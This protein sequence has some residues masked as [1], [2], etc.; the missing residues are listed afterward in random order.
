M[1]TSPLV[2][3][4]IPSF[5]HA[6]YV[7]D[8]IRSVLEQTY[9][10]WQIVVVDDCS[11][12]DSVAIIERFD[13]PRITLI[14]NDRNRGINPTLARAFAASTGEFI[15]VLA[16]DDMLLPDKLERQVALLRRSGADIVYGGGIQLSEDGDR[17]AVDL[18][19]FAR[20]FARGHALRRAYTDDTSLP[21]LQSA[22]F[23]RDAFAA[24]SVYR[25]SVK[26]DDWITLIKAL[27]G[28]RVE[29]RDEPVFL[30]R[31]HATNT[32]RRYEHTFSMRLEII[33][34]A[35]PPAYRVEAL[36]RLFASQ[37]NYLAWD[38]RFAD[39]LRFLTA[40]QCLRPAIGGIIHFA[41]AVVFNLRQRRR[42]G[43]SL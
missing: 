35:T 20:D 15:D 32:F 24:L 42:T 14:R 13:D 27:E 3:V 29:F 16:S 37:A 5:N 30:Y 34:K 18:S 25:E 9:Q 31:Q 33:A 6:S 21:L 41:R 19:A 40:S 7:A 17:T 28:F 8:A 1:N 39:A 26:L 10:S 22:L 12:D 43:R 2:S 23:R 11:H 38:G 36:S 4:L